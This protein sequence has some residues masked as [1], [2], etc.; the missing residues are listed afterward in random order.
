MIH[1][2]I[3]A[4]V[5]ISKTLFYVHSQQDRSGEVVTDAEAAMPKQSQNPH[6]PQ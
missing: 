3:S 1:L 6:G 5:L 4:Q 2:Q